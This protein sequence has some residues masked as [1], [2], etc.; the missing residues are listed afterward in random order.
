MAT[1]ADGT[2][3]CGGGIGLATYGAE[4]CL[5][6]CTHPCLYVCAYVNDFSKVRINEVR[7]LWTR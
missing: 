4:G 2:G 3:Y 5:H 6:V 7:V 1:F